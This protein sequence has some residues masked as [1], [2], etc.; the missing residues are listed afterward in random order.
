[1]EDEENIEERELLMEQLQEHY[2]QNSEKSRKP[3]LAVKLL[4][5][6]NPEDINLKYSLLL[7]TVLYFDDLVRLSTVEQEKNGKNL[8]IIQS[9]LDQRNKNIIRN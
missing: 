4:E 2:T 5:S 3:Y 8:N 6:L 9:F 7:S 1:M